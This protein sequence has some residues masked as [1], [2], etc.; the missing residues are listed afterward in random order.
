MNREEILD[1]LKNP[2]LFECNKAM[3]RTDKLSFDLDNNSLRKSLNG[4]YYFN[5]N[6]NISEIDTNFIENYKQ[7][8]KIKVPS[9]QEI[10][11]Y[12]QAQ[13]VNTQYPWD[14]IEDIS[15]YETP[16][17]HNSCGQYIH[18][19][20]FSKKKKDKYYI[21]FE[22][23]ESMIFIWLNDQFIGFAEDSFTGA[24]FDVT[25]QIKTGENKL[26]IEV[27]KY[28][29]GS[30]LDDQDFWR[31]SGISRNVKI[32][33][34]TNQ[35]VYDFVYDYDV[36]I[37]NPAEGDIRLRL[38]L[39][40]SYDFTVKYKIVEGYNKIIYH[41]ESSNAEIKI[42]LQNIK[43]W[44]PE[45]PAIYKFILETKTEVS[46][47]DIGFRKIEQVGGTLQLNDKK[48]I[49]NGVN[50]HEF[51]P[52]KGR[53]IDYDVI[54][55]DLKLLK[56]LNINAIRTSHYPNSKQFYKLCDKL[57][58]ILMDEVNLETHGT[59]M[60]CGKIA[61]DSNTLP[62]D[63]INFRSRVL[64]RA[65]N[66][67]N[68]DKNYTCILF[69][70]LGNESYGGRTLY[71][72]S[73]YFRSKKDD[74]F[75]HYEGIVLDNRYPKTS[76]VISR[77]YA[78][79]EAVEQLAIDHPDEAVLLCE[80]SHAMGNSNGNISDYYKLVNKYKNFHGG[81]IWEFKE[82][83][84][85]V[86]DK[87]IY[88]GYFDDRPSDYEFIC[89]GISSE[90]CQRTPEFEYIRILFAPMEVKENNGQLLIFNKK[91]YSSLKNIRIEILENTKFENT[92]LEIVNL[93]EIIDF[94]SI[95]LYSSCANIIY[96]I[97]YTEDEYL[98]YSSGKFEDEIETN[99]L[100]EGKFINGD[101]N[102]GIQSDKFSL[103]FSKTKNK[104]TSLNI[105]N[106]EFCGIQSNL[107]QPNFFRARTNNDLGASNRE[108]LEILKHLTYS[109]RSKINF[110]NFTDDIL[111][112]EI[113]YTNDFV[114]NY[115]CII[116]YRIDKK[117]CIDIT[118]TLKKFP[119]SSMYNFG[120]YMELNTPI[121][122]CFYFGHGEFDSYIDRKE[123][124]CLGNFNYDCYM[125]SPY[126]FPQEFGNRTSVKRVS[127]RCKSGSGIDIVSNNFE[128]SAKKYSDLQ[129]DKKIN[130]FDLAP[131]NLF[132]RINQK[133]S[134]VGGDD[135]W[136]SWCKDKY[137]TNFRDECSFN[138]KVYI[139]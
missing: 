15:I 122:D 89:D 54:Y 4:E 99:N 52:I 53:A 70:S 2:E 36:N 75:I 115:E 68:R 38:Y 118:Q 23:F 109:S 121:T 127:F 24:E 48:L 56:K 102:F 92:I 69:W 33:T 96:K 139:K 95:P 27:Y 74:R 67:Y 13:Y 17:K 123:N 112:V 77:M 58:F 84:I 131:E 133:Q 44:N 49:I 79:S 64:A 105:D 124:M 83:I 76:D 106:T 135:S 11:G 111:T 138:F 66:M 126:I 104:I 14:G 8:K 108:S 81:F 72:L 21:E 134:G 120:I 63:N 39:E 22:G 80:Y 51:D 30:W 61:P 42:D 103:I 6:V 136:G 9:N 125:N 85:K 137:Q 3:N 34:E 1:V 93:N 28:C 132:I 37:L 62:N 46:Q 128:F 87:Y 82:Q 73:K 57:G 55:K 32:N 12:G 31:L 100:S 43:L 19:F 110:Y 18:I 113:M 45:I 88:G 107:F 59:W 29:I 40:K 117:G 130:V 86:D 47:Y 26:Y 50:R 60:K 65:R 97:Y 5:Y 94:V 129:L 25:S 7:Y 71:E 41:G 20:D 119:V 90:Y 114:K 10:S 101:Y 116:V 78:S 16:Q 98:L 91:K 35:S